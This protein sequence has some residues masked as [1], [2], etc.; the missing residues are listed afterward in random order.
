MK[1]K[2]ARMKAAASGVLTQDPTSNVTQR[3]RSQ[4]AKDE[5]Q[6]NLKL[7]IGETF[8]PYRNTV[9]F[10]RVSTLKNVNFSDLKF[11]VV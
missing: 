5:R 8:T 1:E 9:N 6:G 11:D 4:R 10:N 3:F 2:I 7:F